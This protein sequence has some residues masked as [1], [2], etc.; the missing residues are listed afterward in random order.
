VSRDECNPPTLFA[1]V[2]F[3]KSKLI[4]SRRSPASRSVISIV[5]WYAAWT[6][7]KRHMR[8][9]TIDVIAL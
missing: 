6:K 2:A 7:M 8:G 9:E 4:P 5:N 1:P 3:K